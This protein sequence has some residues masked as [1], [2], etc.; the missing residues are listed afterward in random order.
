VL[1]L[2][3]PGLEYNVYP[4]KMIRT[5]TPASLRA[6]FRESIYSCPMTMD[7]VLNCVKSKRLSGSFDYDCFL[8]VIVSRYV[9]VGEENTNFE[10]ICMNQFCQWITSLHLADKAKTTSFSRKNLV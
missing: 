8:G 3:R 10:D 6:Q 7:K 5:V 2:G 1:I 4:M 9:L